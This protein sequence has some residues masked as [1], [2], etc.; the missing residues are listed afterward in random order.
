MANRVVM[1]GLEPDVVDFSDPA[2]TAIR[3]LNAA[4]LRA[5]LE[6]DRAAL[7]A[8]G[9]DA[10]WSFWDN[11][12][13]AETKFIDA[14]RTHKPD[15]VMI[16]AGV[17][18]NPRLTS[19]F[20]QLVNLVREHA[21]QSKFCFNSAPYDTAQAVKRQGFVPGPTAASPARH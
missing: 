20:E 15:C 12:A 11:G 16:G 18:L 9:Y 19:L 3:G 1:I 7:V 21:P 6:K 10:I 8:Q 14:L 17:R 5:A 13:G 2:Y 4:K